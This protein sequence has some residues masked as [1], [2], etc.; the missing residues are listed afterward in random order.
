METLRTRIYLGPLYHTINYVANPSF[1]IN[2]S[3]GWSFLDS[4]A[5]A[6]VTL[7]AIQHYVG[8]KSARIRAG[9][10]TAQMWTTLG[11]LLLPNG[12][13]CTLSARIRC[14]ANPGA[15]KAYIRLVSSD[16]SLVGI[17]YATGASATAWQ[18][19]T[20]TITNNTGA[21]KDMQ[22]ILYND[23][24]DS[25]NDTWFDGI[26]LEITATATPYCDGSLDTWH[27]WD[28]TAHNSVSR[29]LGYEWVLCPDVLQ[30]PP[31]AWEYGLAGTDVMDLVATT[32]IATFA[33]DN[34]INNSTGLAGH[35]SPGHANCLAGFGEDCLVKIAV[36]HVVASPPSITPTL[37]AEIVLN[38]GFETAGGG[39]A[40][41]WANWTE[42]AGDGALANET[43]LVHSG[44]DA[45]KLTCGPTLYTTYIFQYI[46]VTPGATY[47]FSYWTKDDGAHGCYVQ[48]YDASNAA[49][50][51]D[52]AAPRGTTYV[53]VS[54]PF[55]APVGCV[56][57]AMAFYA[58]LFNTSI[59]YFDDVS[60]KPVTVE[61]FGSLQTGA[62]NVSISANLT[63]P[64]NLQGGVVLALD[65]DTAPANWIVARY[66][67]YDG[68]IYVDQY[69]ADVLTN[70][71]AT[72][73]AYVAGATLVAIKANG[74]VTVYYNGSL[75]GSPVA[76]TETAYTLCGLFATDVTV[77]FANL[78]VEL[79][80]F[81][82]FVHSIDPASGLFD[83]QLV[84]VEAHD[85]MEFASIQEL[86]II[87]IAV[88]KRADEA[89]TTALANFLI[90][91]M[92][93][94]LDASVETFLKVFDTDDSS[95]SMA[96]LFQ[97]LCRNEAFGRIYLKGDGTL[98]FENRDYRAAYVGVD[99][100]LDSLMNQLELVWSRTSIRN[101]INSRIFPA[102]TETGATTVL[103]E[104]QVPFALAPTQSITIVADFRDP[105]TGKRCSGI[106][107]V[108]PIDAADI[109]FG[110]DA[111][112]SDNR[113]I[114]GL[115]F[116]QTVG[117]HSSK[118]VLTNIGD[119]TGYVNILRVRGDG[120]FTYD[121]IDVSKQDDESIL[122]RGEKELNI[123]LEQIADP[124]TANGLGCILLALLKDPTSRVE[125]LRFN[126][127]QSAA[128]ADVAVHLEP[129]YR[130]L[131][132]ED[133][134]GVD[135][136]Y[137]ANRIKFE[138]I[139]PNLECEII[140]VPQG[141]IGLW[142][143]DASHWDSA[144][145]GHWGF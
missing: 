5:G 9:N 25:T 3:D 69:I 120:I 94:D 61:S 47:Q 116:P 145:D 109:A 7:D 106:N 99:F 82:G 64:A 28:G 91:P 134:T 122:L 137:W 77:T 131:L 73:T 84:D 13:S 115:T 89:L 102:E 144:V 31:P 74:Y 76:V 140:C 78:A 98:C 49:T 11:I 81:I 71:A 83:E 79:T 53:Q 6:S 92:A 4:G 119:M 23:F 104:L 60:V 117:G 87:P 110:Y 59:A 66:N 44:S 126:C 125:R 54:V 129:S 58:P 43:T 90:P 72:T 57:V 46:A 132:K 10:N 34:G 33:L 63:I 26:Q 121:A 105:T 143:W 113:M 18:T 114:A 111:D 75:V 16:W 52:S 112:G 32:G 30:E 2:V 88:N 12:A 65:S 41:I 135:N 62:V 20:V 50:L 55:V 45:A 85:W 118:I 19:V 35:Y 139:G 70:L 136:Y 138:Q 101:K 22:A 141:A 103:Y 51:W 15:N 124:Y 100:Q 96:S 95:M 68:K 80:R 14:S 97:K 40:D 130:F 48:L 27:S 128:L 127:N 24:K 86:G 56:S 39:G 1:E 17:A 36:E 29:G 108:D 142:I 133:M 123:N 38:P 93:V 42:G 8:T 67:R 107:I 37:G 21:I